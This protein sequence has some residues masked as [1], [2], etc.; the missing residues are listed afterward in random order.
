VVRARLLTTLDSASAKQGEPVEAALAAPLFSADH[1]LVLPEGTR[2]IG[3]VTVAKKARS[4]HRGGQLRFAFQQVEL[5]AEVANLRPAA[6]AP[7]M[8][9]TQATLE[10]AEASGPAPIKVDSEGGVQ[11]QESK[12]RFIAP[13]ISLLLAA[14]AADNDAG[15]HHAAEGSGGEANVSGRT[16]G[17]ASG[18]GLLGVALSQSS[19]YV[20]MAFGYYGLAWSVYSNVIGRGG[21]VQFDKNAMMDIRLGGRTPPPGSKF[22]EVAAGMDP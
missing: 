5:P 13:V 10:A 16:L 9:K 8:L 3:K 17:G 18:F 21:E 7:P 19:P 6:P 2:L 20:G 11:A 4:F 1:K 22:R 15:H 12:T 14:R